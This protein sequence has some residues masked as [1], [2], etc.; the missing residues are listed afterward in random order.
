MTESSAQKGDHKGKGKKK[1]KEE[2]EEKGK[3][4]GKGK[5]SAGEP[6]CFSWGRGRD[7]P[8]KDLPCKSECPNKR[9]HACEFCEAVDHKSKDCPKKPKWAKW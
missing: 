4:K 1:G 7:G 2:K 9:L 8:C 5:S 6:F 3:G